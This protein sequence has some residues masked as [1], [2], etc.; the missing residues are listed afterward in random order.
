MMFC[1]L[2][3]CCYSSGVLRGNSCEICDHNASF[4]ASALDS[5]G[6]DTSLVLDKRYRTI[7]VHNTHPTPLEPIESRGP[8]S[9][10]MAIVVK[11][12]LGSSGA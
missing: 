12:I 7:P 10:S 2:G 6:W 11:P 3:K 8:S 4:L 5:D 9:C 1:T